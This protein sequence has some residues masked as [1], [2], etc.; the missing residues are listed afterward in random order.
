M[1][2]FSRAWRFEAF[3]GPQ[4]RSSECFYETCTFLD[5]VGLVPLGFHASI[6][7]DTY[8]ER[9]IRSIH[10]QRIRE[11]R[12]ATNGVSQW[13][14]QVSDCHGFLQREPARK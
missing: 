8:W 3:G 10:E 13:N 1:H 4:R 7:R 2:A 14:L 6:G 11:Q 5:N 12:E 9:L